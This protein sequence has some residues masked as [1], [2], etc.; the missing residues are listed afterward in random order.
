MAVALKDCDDCIKE[1]GKE[2]IRIFNNYAMILLDSC[3][4]TRYPW[5]HAVADSVMW[6][7]DMSHIIH[8]L[9]QTA[10][11]E[12]CCS[13]GILNIYQKHEYQV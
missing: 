1:I 7:I 4:L 12:A 11:S 8:Q 10:S 6:Y 9:L 5:C 2:K 3:N 13:G